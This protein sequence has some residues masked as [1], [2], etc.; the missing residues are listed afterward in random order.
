PG[1]SHAARADQSADPAWSVDGE[2]E[3]TAEDTVLQTTARWSDMLKRHRARG[4]LGDAP[5]HRRLQMLGSCDGAQPLRHALQQPQAFEWRPAR[6]GNALFGEGVGN[7][8]G[9]ELTASSRR[10]PG[11][12]RNARRVWHPRGQANRDD[13]GQDRCDPPHHGA[14]LLMTRS[15]SSG[16]LPSSRPEGDHLGSPSRLAEAPRVQ[17]GV[18]PALAQELRMAYWLLD[19]SLP[20]HQHAAGL[21][22][23]VEVVGS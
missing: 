9:T 17:G 5:L 10:M 7:L 2:L 4:E 14:V 1:I 11:N 8:F 18:E 20:D 16:S 19:P 13:R 21:T 23:Q 15:P 3:H 6:R 12:F 22:D